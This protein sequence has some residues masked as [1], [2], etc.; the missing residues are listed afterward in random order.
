VGCGDDGVRLDIVSRDGIAWRAS[1]K[2]TS[3]TRV[4]FE[5]KN[6]WIS[7]IYIHTSDRIGCYA[8]PSDAEGADELW[9]T[10]EKRGLIDS[11]FA[12]LALAAE[13][14]VHC[15]P[16]NTNLARDDR[17][18]EQ[19]KAIESQRDVDKERAIRR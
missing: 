3:I 19:L 13:K 14:G 4:C 18:K 16:L 2:W 8:I 10:L 11:A 9:R 5:A 12:K 17:S 15:Y 6:L 7:D 1:F